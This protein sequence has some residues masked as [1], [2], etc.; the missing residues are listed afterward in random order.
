MI[1]MQKVKLL[2]KMLR[3]DMGRLIAFSRKQLQDAE[4]KFMF[5]TTF[6]RT[7]NEPI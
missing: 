2:L 7:L 5:M 3:L 6:D 4:N 1:K